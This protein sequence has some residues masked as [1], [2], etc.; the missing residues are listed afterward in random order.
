M[1]TII[2]LESQGCG[3]NGGDT[4]EVQISCYPA[5]ESGSFQMPPPPFRATGQK[6]QP[7]L[8]ECWKIQENKY[9]PQSACALEKKRAVVGGKRGVM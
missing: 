6:G 4:G 1:R 3:G 2:I 9:T 5:W 8:K 7:L